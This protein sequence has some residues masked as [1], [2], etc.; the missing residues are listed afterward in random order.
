MPELEKALTGL[1]LHLERF[2]EAIDFLEHGPKM[3]NQL[4]LVVL[5][6]ASLKVSPL[7]GPEPLCYLMALLKYCHRHQVPQRYSTERECIKGH[8]GS[9]LCKSWGNFKA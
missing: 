3:A 5:F 7:A 2:D 1:T 9:A 6:E 8:L 4:S